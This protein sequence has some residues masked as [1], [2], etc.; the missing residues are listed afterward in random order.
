MV[1]GALLVAG[2]SSA[3]D[4]SLADKVR[5]E[6]NMLPYYSVFDAI[7]YQVTGDAVTLSGAVHYP[8]LASDAA[9]V[10]KSIPGVGSVSNQIEVLPLSRFDDQIRLAAWRTVYSWPTMSRVA[11]MPLPPV[12]ILVKNGDITLVGMVPSQADKD[13]LNLRVNGIPNVFSVKNELVVENPH[14]HQS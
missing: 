9:N 10:V 8:I 11:S 13:A 12:R 4:V 7:T 14:A 2:S 3:K 6:L 5:H 1:F